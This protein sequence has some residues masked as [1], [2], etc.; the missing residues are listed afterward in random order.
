MHQIGQFVFAVL[1]N[2]GEICSCKTHTKYALFSKTKLRL[3]VVHHEVGCRGSERK[4]RH[5]GQ[6]LTNHF[7]LQIRRA[8]I[9]A[10]LRDAVRLIHR[11][12]THL[13][14]SQFE[15]ENLRV[16]T[17]GR[18]IEKLVASQYHIVKLL[19][20][21][22][23]RQSRVDGCG[24]DAFFAQMLHLVF[25][26]SNEWSDDD[27][28]ALHHQGWCLK[29]DALA[30]ACGHKPQCVAPFQDAVHN[31]ALNAAKVGIAP[32]ALQHN[33]RISGNFSFFVSTDGVY[34]GQI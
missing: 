24:A 28:S 18:E 31:V 4:N 5:I 13:H 21:F 32:H 7:H 1:H 3:N 16:Q 12:E 34:R 26:Q 15:F 29:G 25:H 27:A 22:L 30:T 8:K 33:A 10:P 6:Q 2:V 9:I 23:S 14:I 11:N 20:D 19:I 17:L